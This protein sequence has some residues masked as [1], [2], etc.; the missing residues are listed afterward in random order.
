MYGYQ[1]SEELSTG[2]GG[3]FGL[4]SG[5]F[6]TKFEYNANA[7]SDGAVADA[8]DLTV[9]VGEREY[10]KRFFPVSKVYG[11]GN[12]GEL[13][14]TTTDEY[15]AAKDTA[16]SLLNASLTDV[17]RVFVDEESIKSALSSPIASFK[18]YALVLE[19]LVKGSGNWDKTPVDVFLSYQ[20]AIQGDNK[21]T[22]LE[23]PKDVKH[24]SFIIKSLGEGYKEVAT[25]S[26]IKYTNEEGLT[27]PF[28]RSEWFANSAYAIQAVIEEA[29]TQDMGGGAATGGNW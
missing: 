27:H 5:V 10:R 11:K 15:K 20:W 19:R 25:S 22:F 3:K 4:N 7:G 1:N 2:N 6:I 16:V 12:V 9:K 14:D 21:R 13:T 17:V 24:G 28:K 8:I 18:D 29:P 26:S 23:I